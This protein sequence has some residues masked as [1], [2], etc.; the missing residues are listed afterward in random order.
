VPYLF[1]FGLAFQLL[2]GLKGI[3][4]FNF[5]LE[6]ISLLSFTVKSLVIL[7]LPR[8]LIG[9]LPALGLNEGAIFPLALKPSLSLLALG[10]PTVAFKFPRGLEVKP[11][12]PLGFEPVEPKLPFLG[13]AVLP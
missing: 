10:L 3:S 6:G 2:F 4:F 12:L 8:G 9:G 5:G 11:R 7:G 13:L 1:I